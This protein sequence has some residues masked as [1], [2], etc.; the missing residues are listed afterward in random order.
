M[1]LEC[2]AS[3]LPSPEHLPL[4]ALPFISTYTCCWA[5]QFPCFLNSA[6]SVIAGI[7]FHIPSTVSG[8]DDTS[9]LPFKLLF[10]TVFTHLASFSTF[11][12]LSKLN[13]VCGQHG[14]AVRKIEINIC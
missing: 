7:S 6:I 1:G 2:Q 8:R 10:V 3:I 14:Q 13:E 9:N 5:S 11:Q 12:A 4:F